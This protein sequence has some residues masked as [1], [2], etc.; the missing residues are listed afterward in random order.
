MAK[1]ILMSLGLK[2]PRRPR[3]LLKTEEHKNKIAKSNQATKRKIARDS[4]VPFHVIIGDI[5]IGEWDLA[6][7]CAED[8]G[9]CYS[10]ILKCLKGRQKVHKGY[11]FKYVR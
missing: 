5:I 1:V 9:L 3:G 8:L 10:S 11:R 2:Y 7:E 4:A 6:V